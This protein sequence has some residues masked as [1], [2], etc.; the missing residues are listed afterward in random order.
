MMPF[1]KLL[2]ANIAVAG[3]C[4]V[5]VVLLAIDPVWALALALLLLAI[6]GAWY[7]RS[8]GTVKDVES[9]YGFYRYHYKR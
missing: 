8:T 2:G 7:G 3:L 6:G 4:A 9:R 5:F 1:F